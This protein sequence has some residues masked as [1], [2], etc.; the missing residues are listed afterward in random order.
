MLLTG[1]GGSVGGLLLGLWYASKNSSL[2]GNSK[3][4]EA[5]ELMRDASRPIV[6]RLDKTND[7][8]RSLLVEQA[9]VKGMLSS[10]NQK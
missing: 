7:L 10:L 6:E 5:A 2:G 4:S 3:E 1:S 8:L 9:E